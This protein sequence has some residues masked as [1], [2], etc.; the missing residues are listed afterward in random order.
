M[1]KRAGW[2]WS[3]QSG[4]RVKRIAGQNG[5]ILNKSIRLWVKQVASQNRSILKKLIRLRVELS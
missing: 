1:A 4:L 3:G 5:S 2:V